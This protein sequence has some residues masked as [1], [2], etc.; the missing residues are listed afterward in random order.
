MIGPSG[1][2]KSYY[3]YNLKRKLDEDTNVVLL[4][5]D[6]FRAAISNV[7]DQ[8]IH[9]VV[10]DWIR[11]SCSY[12]LSKDYDVIIDATSLTVSDRTDYIN[13]GKK[14]NSNI[15]A[16][17]LTTN[18]EKCLARNSVRGRVVPTHVI[19]KQFTK[20]TLPT[21]NEGFNNMITV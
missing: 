4:S 20:L 11:K 17:F 8:T 10:F 21:Y 12:F 9:G 5:S 16:V 1:S 14:Y 3:A 19:E 7:N 2:G 13:I 6:D 18:K 15:I